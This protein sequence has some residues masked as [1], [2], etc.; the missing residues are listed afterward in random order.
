MLESPLACA[1]DPDCMS[2][3]GWRTGRGALLAAGF[4]GLVAC[5]PGRPEPA[6]SPERIDARGTIPEVLAPLG[7]DGTVAEIPSRIPGARLESIDPAVDRFA[8]SNGLVIREIS[9]PRG[10]ASGAPRTPVDLL[11]TELA[12]TDRFRLLY[13]TEGTL[14][15]IVPVA[16]AAAKPTGW[17]MDLTPYT[18]G[19]DR[20]AS[21]PE[22][23]LA[24]MAR[25]IVRRR[26]RITT[27]LR[28][29]GQSLQLRPVDQ[30][31]KKP[32]V[33]ATLD[34]AAGAVDLDEFGPTDLLDDARRRTIVATRAGGGRT[35]RVI[36]PIFPTVYS[37][38]IPN[39]RAQARNMG[40]HVHRTLARLDPR[41][42]DQVLDVGTGSGYLSWVAWATARERGRDV[43]MF[44][45]DINPL[46]VANARALARLAG[47]PLT[48]M[49]HD[50]VV[51]P[52]GT[53]AFAGERFRIMIWDM[54]A[55]P[56]VVRPLLDAPPAAEETRHLMTYWDDGRGAIE[57]LQRL[58]RAL[59]RLLAETPRAAS[60]G[61]PA[62]APS[63]A[64]VWNALPDDLPDF[65][66]RTFRDAGL[67]SEVLDT[68]TSGGGA[69]RC[70]VLGVSRQG[71]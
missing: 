39:N 27:Y 3:H 14:D 10:A 43:R 30:Q 64:V 66:D 9:V 36:Y 62:D 60:T 37:P 53:P 22:D 57:S 49:V 12:D 42:A 69:V 35:L 5:G 48:T 15:A 59:P 55:L 4:A 51:D 50:N 8:R 54:P 17:Y 56:R 11:R 23:E 44:S 28:F 65:I 26:E 29:S 71:D 20:F 18:T 19:I 7:L 58:A 68:Y 70:V 52:D 46:A 16:G 24:R 13:S 47:Y 25:D 6:L 61:R 33:L 41:D 40:G 34:A 21:A 67:R 38:A 1:G 45:I 63:T 32:Y 31:A 2:R